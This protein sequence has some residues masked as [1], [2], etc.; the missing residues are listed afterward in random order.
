MQHLV[1]SILLAQGLTFCNWQAVT[2][3]DQLPFLDSC[4][5]LPFPSILPTSFSNPWGSPGGPCCPQ[6]GPGSLQDHREAQ[7]S[8]LALSHLEP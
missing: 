1:L 8:L 3:D 7:C 4:H 5:L 6:P 2:C